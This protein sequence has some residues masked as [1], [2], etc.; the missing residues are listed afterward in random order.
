[1]FKSI[2]SLQRQ[3]S[4]NDA[5][6]WLCGDME[7]KQVELVVNRIKLG[8]MYWSDMK[9]AWPYYFCIC[10]QYELKQRQIK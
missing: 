3:F 2:S 7:W 1:M 9:S 8:I 5:F 10:P 6:E 4:S